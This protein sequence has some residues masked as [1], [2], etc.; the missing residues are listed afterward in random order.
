MD[1]I[2]WLFFL[3]HCIVCTSI[4]KA[5]RA[6]A[7]VSLSP[8]TRGEKG[9]FLVVPGSDATSEINGIVLVRARLSIRL[10][11][12]C[13]V[14]SGQRDHSINIFNARIIDVATTTTP[15]HDVYLSLLSSATMT[16]DQLRSLLWCICKHWQHFGP[17]VAATGNERNRPFDEGIDF[18][19]SLSRSVVPKGVI[20]RWKWRIYFRT[21]W[22]T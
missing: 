22:F 11:S 13:L 14:Y 10:P 3:L 16:V 21:A 12:L 6:I 4:R 20:G 9:V 5:R 19:F 8:C 15:Y 2:S 7:R 1:Q 17:L 18:V